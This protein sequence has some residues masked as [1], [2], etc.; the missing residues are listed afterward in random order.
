MALPLQLTTLLTLNICLFSDNSHVALKILTHDSG[1]PSFSFDEVGLL[2]RIKSTTAKHAGRQHVVLMKHHF[3]HKGPNGTHICIELEPLGPSIREIERQFRGIGLPQTL[4]KQIASQILLSLDFL[5]GSC[6]II[7]SGTCYPHRSIQIEHRLMHATSADIKPDNVLLFS[8][9][10]EEMIRR[11]IFAS[12]PR[13]HALA[14]NSESAPSSLTVSQPLG[15]IL[16]LP[17]T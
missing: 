7:F 12:S 13:T 9:N 16:P 10:I 4:V 15:W 1:T 14:R 11:D 3:K 6:G 8:E 5:H 17:P 2:H